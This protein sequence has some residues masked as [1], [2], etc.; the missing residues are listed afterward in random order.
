VLTQLL[1]NPEAVKALSF[2]QD[3][4]MKIRVRRLCGG[5]GRRTARPRGEPQT[6]ER[7]V[8]NLKA[9]R[10]RISKLDADNLAA[11][12]Q[13]LHARTLKVRVGRGSSVQDLTL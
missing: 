9:L 8:A 11:L 2:L 13:F 4:P 1:A 3:I 7:K 5:C 10:E 12:K 6:V